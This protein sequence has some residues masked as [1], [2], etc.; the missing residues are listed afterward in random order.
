MRFQ[1][2]EKTVGGPIDILVI[3]P[4]QE[5]VFI[6]KKELLLLDFN[7]LFLLTSVQTIILLLSSASILILSTTP[8]YKFNP[9]Y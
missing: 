5:P 6:Q 9:N 3:Q 1:Q 2:K 8:S 7:L 4:H